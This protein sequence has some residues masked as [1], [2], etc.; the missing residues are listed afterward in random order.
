MGK[1]LSPSYTTPPVQGQRDTQT[2]Y[3]FDYGAQSFKPSTVSTNIGS[4]NG[5]TGST[6]DIAQSAP[7][8]RNQTPLVDTQNKSANQEKVDRQN[9]DNE[10][11]TLVGDCSVVVSEKNVKRLETQKVVTLDGLG[12][13]LSGSYMITSTK[14]SLDSSGFSF[15]M[16]VRKTGFRGTSLKASQK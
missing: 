15:T 6:D 13:N 16:Q 3:T 7:T 9:N 4:A 12:K 1:D 14:V 5:N 10:I 2:Q 11:I 8:E